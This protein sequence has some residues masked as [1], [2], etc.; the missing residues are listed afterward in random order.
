MYNISQISIDEAKES[1]DA[2]E[3][4]F[5]DIRDPDSYQAAHIPGAVNLNN[6]NVHDFLEQTDKTQPIIVYCY[7][8]NSSLNGSAFFMEQGF[9]TVHS[10]IGGFHAWC[11]LYPHTTD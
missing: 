8:G 10:M 7:H 1:L 5:V 9:E 2:G 3:T 6:E 4:V 11:T